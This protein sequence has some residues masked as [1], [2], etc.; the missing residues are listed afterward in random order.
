MATPFISPIK[1]QGGTFYQF[2][3]AIEDFNFNISSSNKEFVFSKFVCL[4]LPN[5]KDGSTGIN[6]SLVS[7]QPTT[8]LKSEFEDLNIDFAESFQNYC[9]N[10]ESMLINNPTYQE[11]KNLTVSE[12]VFW[13][14]LK[15]LGA[16]RF[17][18]ANVGN[19][20]DGGER[21]RR[22]G[23][24]ITGKRFVEEDSREAFVSGFYP[25]SR[26][27]QYIG[28]IDAVNSV[29]YEG[30]GFTELYL[31]MPV[32]TGNTPK[33][34]FK[35][36]L[37]DS[38][39][40]PNMLLRHSPNDSL[41]SETIFGRSYNDTHPL[42]LGIRAFFDSDTDTLSSGSSGIESYSLNIKKNGED[43]YEDGWWF[44][45]PS[46]NSYMTDL[47]LNDWRSDWCKIEGYKNSTYIEREFLRSRLDGISIDFDLVNSYS[48]NLYG[49][50][51]SFEDYSKSA[52]S[53]DFEFNV[54]LVYYDLIDKT[55]S[56][57]N[58]TNLFGVWFVDKWKD[59][60]TN[61]WEIERYK[62]FKPNAINRQNGNSYA[63][64]INLKLD[65]N[66]QDNVPVKS[67]NEYNNFSMHLFMDALNSM[68]KTHDSLISNLNSLKL[69]QDKIDVLEDR[70]A[71]E[72]TLETLSQRISS[73]ETSLTSSQY[74]LSNSKDIMSL[75]DRNYV[76]ITNIYKNLTSVEM[77]YNLDVLN[78]GKGI[79]F[80]KTIPGRLKINTINDG[81]N[82]SKS[83]ILEYSNIQYDVK[84]NFIYHT[85]ELQ[86]YTNYIKIV[87]KLDVRQPLVLDRNQ[88][89]KLF[90]Q[91]NIDWF[92]GQVVRISFG[93]AF[94]FNNTQ[95]ALTILTDYRNLV[96]SKQRYSVVCGTLSTLD[97]N[98]K[99]NK[100]IIEVICIDSKKMLFTID[101]L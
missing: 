42:G 100:P 34:L 50:F 86:E 1:N 67:V 26:V 14:W 31:M 68:K 94:V 82:L 76:E 90:I 41:D 28:N 89:F 36:I 79:Q 63:W 3:S 9:L 56:S 57:K 66:A 27:V 37:D 65:L 62:K 6:T 80:D 45:N 40:A 81:Y 51:K 87:N 24:L 46:R 38:N 59:T 29:K 5:Q 98:N 4:N 71:E 70:I 55:D 97:F 30:S 54:I 12:R 35:S 84:D 33:I 8:F 15:E 19:P 93:D 7:N 75:I 44:P 99:S 16:I 88:T 17:R 18:E 53:T 48:D 20:E 77:S 11:S 13:K 83:P 2:Q 72:E 25:Y 101:I 91:D 95:Y 32:E 78:A 21:T 52:L 47:E 85:H 23:D 64:K 49:N 96:K 92:N 39:Y 10:F 43:S 74:L 22:I 69:L 61:G 60:L 58:V 73:L